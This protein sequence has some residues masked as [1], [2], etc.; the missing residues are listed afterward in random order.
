MGVLL[1]LIFGIGALTI[2]LGLQPSEPGKPARK[3][4]VVEK[5]VK[6]R[7]AIGAG[8]V[9][10]LAT[11]V[12]TGLPF[13][14]LLA[15]ILGCGVPTM[16][17]RRKQRKI[18]KAR[19]QAWPEVIDSLASA[20]R[21]GMSLPEAVAGV[22]VRGPEILRPQFQAFADDYRT[23]G[24]FTQSLIALR[25]SLGDPVADRVIEALLMARE[26]GG[27]DLGKMLRTLSEFVRQDLRLRAEAEARQ[28]WTVNGARLAVAAPWLVLLMLSTRPEA[29]EAYRTA[30]GMVVLAISAVVCVLAYALMLR[31]GRLPEEKRVVA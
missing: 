11:A 19:R 31:L 5:F 2:W 15:M 7:V 26:V 13:A 24:R 17:A 10:A 8:I 6:Y 1:G 23:T 30:A 14:G 29:A 4:A 18:A 9:C 22:A 16:I 3:I 25:D 12:V 28:S 21:A 20:V 27:T